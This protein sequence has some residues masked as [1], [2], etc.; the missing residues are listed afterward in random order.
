M[1]DKQ[2]SFI[3]LACR[4]VGCDAMKKLVFSRP[5]GEG[6]TKVSARLCAHRGKRIVALEYSLPS[7]T[8]T[9]KNLTDGELYGELSEL[10]C[11]F[12]QANLITTLGEVEWKSSR[13]GK[14]ALL[15]ADKLLRKLDG[16]QCFEA[17]IESL[18]RKK[19]YI[20]SGSEPFLTGLGVSDKNGRVHDK[21]QGKFRQ[22]NRFI[23]HISDVYP[24]LSE[25]GELVIYD[26][27]CGKSYLSFAT[28]YY[29]TKIK[30]R[31][32]RML[33]IDLKR[34]VIEYCERTARELGFT[35]MQFI[36][37]DIRETPADTV[38]DMVISLHACDIAT[39]IVL[40]TAARLGA[41]VILSTPCCH[42]YMKDKIESKELSFITDYP[43]VANKLAEAATDALRLL[44]LSASGYR[45]SALEL[46]DPDDTPKNTL[47]RA[48]KESGVSEG[49]LMNRKGAYDTALAFLMPR[50]KDEY[51]KEIK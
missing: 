33:S 49:E 51:L 26:L 44:K 41:K 5:V 46:T 15:G 35:G 13:S 28:Y 47:I 48:V 11:A 38:P 42:R 20:L 36:A 18:D 7:S 22:I 16:E 4:T 43:H 31:S 25:S 10:I 2:K 23:E 37:A 39:D 34:D 21:K 3:D 17:A 19:N 32:V 1:T 24:S 50:G 40:D 12:S 8:V 9:H 30:G 45:V 29:L 14:E 6:A 27:C